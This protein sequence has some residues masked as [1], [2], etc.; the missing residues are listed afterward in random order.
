MSY[1]FFLG[2]G[3]PPTLPWGAGWALL[4]SSGSRGHGLFPKGCCKAV[5]LPWPLQGD[6]GWVTS[7]PSHLCATQRA[8]GA[9]QG[10]HPQRWQRVSLLCCPSPVVPIPWLAGDTGQPSVT[11]PP[12][13]EERQGVVQGA[14][15]WVPPMRGPVGHH[16][17]LAAFA[18]LPGCCFPPTHL[19]ASQGRALCV[20]KEGAGV[21]I[22]W[23]IL[24]L[25]CHSPGTTPAHQ[26]PQPQGEPGPATLLPGTKRGIEGHSGAL[27]TPCPPGRGWLPSAGF[28]SPVLAP[29]PQ[30][31][32][33]LGAPMEAVTP[34]VHG[35]PKGAGSICCSPGAVP[36]T[37]GPHSCAHPSTAPPRGAK[38]LGKAAA[39]FLSKG[40]ELPVWGAESRSL[41]WG[42]PPVPCWRVLGGREGDRGAS[43]LSH[44][45]RSP[46][47]PQRAARGK[48]SPSGAG[49]ASPEP[50]IRGHP[51]TPHTPPL[52]ASLFL[53]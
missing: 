20:G 7:L 5:T 27:S 21:P 44:G 22:R 45:G 25:S 39:E 53:L 40:G 48:H 16:E 9:A 47:L 13:G 52:Q 1:F 51:M 12:G 37:W 46:P 8:K 31:P 35:A 30:H 18:Q 6:C 49:G 41:G 19:R 32:G 14:R 24:L 10:C 28:P 50:P 23:P 11:L 36:V 38:G 4:V 3:G 15:R 26:H 42:T 43:L 2:A 29:Q 17:A 33:E 34:M